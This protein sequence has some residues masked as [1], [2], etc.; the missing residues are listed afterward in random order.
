MM[1]G[2]TV[3]QNNYLQGA[4]EIEK[5][6]NLGLLAKRIKVLIKKEAN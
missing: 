4:D 6:L 2:C 1:R 3:R 5:T